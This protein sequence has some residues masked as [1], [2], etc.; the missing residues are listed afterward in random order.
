MY[1]FQNKTIN[2]LLV[3]GASI[4]GFIIFT[5]I[6]PGVVSTVLICIFLW[7][8]MG[9]IGWSMGRMSGKIEDVEGVPFYKEVKF[10]EYIARGPITLI[11][12]FQ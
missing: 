6:L 4:L 2:K 1:D 9:L 8:F 5:L 7:S 10:Y 12:Y 3:I 11:K